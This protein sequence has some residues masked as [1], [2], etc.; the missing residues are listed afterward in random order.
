MGEA[1]CTMNGSIT[2]CNENHDLAGTCAPMPIITKHV[3]QPKAY[4][5]KCKVIPA[6]SCKVSNCAFATAM[7]LGSPECPLYTLAAAA[8][9][10]AY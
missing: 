9:N 6:E 5:R 4:P 1:T 10:H 7:W 8:A 2:Q 3:Q